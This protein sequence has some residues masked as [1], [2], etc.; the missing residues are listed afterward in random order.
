VTDLTGARREANLNLERMK[1]RAST[2]GWITNLQLQIGS[3]AATGQAAMTLVDA[4]A[5][6][7]KATSR[8]R[9]LARIAVGDRA[10]AV[11][12]DFPGQAVAGHISGIGRG[13]A[14]SDAAAGVKGLPAVNPVFN[15]VRLAQRIPVRMEIDDV[16]LASFCR[17]A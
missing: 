10:R 1:I 5:S 11:L 6:G 8:R 13:I 7:S 4:Q 9:K 17:P 16:P 2:D 14:V 3:F 15:W 12:L